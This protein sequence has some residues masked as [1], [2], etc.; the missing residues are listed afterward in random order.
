MMTATS[1]RARGLGPLFAQAFQRLTGEQSGFRAGMD[2]FGRVLAGLVTEMPACGMSSARLGSCGGSCTVGARDGLLAVLGHLS[3]RESDERTLAG[4]LSEALSVAWMDLVARYESHLLRLFGSLRTY[5]ETEDLLPWVDGRT[6]ARLARAR[7]AVACRD[8]YPSDD[9]ECVL[10]F[11]AMVWFLAAALKSTL[12]GEEAEGWRN[13]EA[14][15]LIA[16]AFRRRHLAESTGVARELAAAIAEHNEDDRALW[17]EFKRYHDTWFYRW[18]AMFGPL[19]AWLCHEMSLCPSGLDKAF[20]A[21]GDDAWDL[22]LLE[23][24]DEARAGLG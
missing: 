8:D 3:D 12:R 2:A 20:Q 4:L 1:D 24:L 22:P 10:R 21:L 16:E 14:A 23:L 6:R 18:W 5:L 13:L 7:I 17:E 19:H 15:L 11:Q 9:M